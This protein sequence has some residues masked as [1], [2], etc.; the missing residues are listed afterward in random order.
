MTREMMYTQAEM[1]NNIRFEDRE[2]IARL[3]RYHG[4]PL[5]FAEKSNTEK[6][7]LQASLSTPMHLLALVAEADVKGRI[8]PDKE[9]LIERV[10][11]FRMYCQDQECYY[12]PKQFPSSHTKF[13]YF[14]RDDS[15]SNYPVYDDTQFEAVLMSGLPGAG[16]DTYI[17]DE[18]RDWP[19]ISLDAL[20]EQM[21]VKPTDNQGTV[22]QAA[23][24]QAK[25]MM[26]RKQSF[27][28]NATNITRSL[29]ETLISLF[30]IY[31]A[32]I[33]IVYIESSH[34]KLQQQNLGREEIV[35]PKVIVRLIQ[36]MEVPDP[37]EAHE[38]VYVIH[39]D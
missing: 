5:W 39:E 21:G 20:R 19:V 27:V 11:F 30:R 33:R 12:H 9:A 10:E 23:K 24:E 2:K 37:S 1:F 18:F 25:V 3:V 34:Q 32:R 36:K 22:I 15:F 13:M 26:R 14:E 38:V 7:I 6:A 29:R 17:L 31:N 28:W 4:L 8:C 35:P 16:K